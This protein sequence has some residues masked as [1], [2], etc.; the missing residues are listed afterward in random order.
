[1]SYT[2]TLCEE[3]LTSAEPVAVLVRLLGAVPYLTMEATLVGLRASNA[4]VPVCRYAK[5]CSAAYRYD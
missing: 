4:P 3:A 1:M 2:V 5:Y